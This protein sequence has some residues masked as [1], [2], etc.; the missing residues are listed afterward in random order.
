MCSFMC[1]FPKLEHVVHYKEESQNTVKNKL[2]L[3][4]AR[5][6]THTHTQSIG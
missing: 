1:Y 2:P 5:V 3:A 6:H 4:R